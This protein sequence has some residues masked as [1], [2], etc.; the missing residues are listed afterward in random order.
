LPAFEKGLFQ[1]VL[2]RLEIFYGESDNAE[3][4]AEVQKM[5]EH[6]QTIETVNDSA[7]IINQ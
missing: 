4:V 2:E 6:L 7:S 3:R 1:A 5:L